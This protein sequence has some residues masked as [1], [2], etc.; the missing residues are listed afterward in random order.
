M[1]LGALLKFAQ[2]QGASDLHLE[3]GLPMCLRVRGE[4]RSTGEP[5][6]AAAIS[7]M[8]LELLSPEDWPEFQERR[9]FDLS[10]V[11]QGV[12]VRVNALRT[13]RGVGLAIRLLAPFQA[14]KTVLVIN[15][16]DRKD[17]RAPDVLDAVYSLYIDLGADETQLEFP[18][19]YAVARAGQ[20]SLKLDV[21]GTS[22]QPLFEA[23]INHISPPAAPPE[24]EDKL[25]LLV[26]NLDYDD[27]VGRLIIGR[28]HSGKITP[29]MP[30]SVV[31][32]GGKIE[33]GKIIKLFGFMGLKRTELLDAGPGEIVSIAGI[34]NVSIGDTIT[35]PDRPKA[36][37][38]ISVDE[39]TMMMVFKVN[40]GPL[41]GREGK[42][43]TS[44]NLR[45]RLYK[46]SYRNVS[47]RVEDT[48][49][50]DSFRV[51]GRGELAPGDDHRDHAPRGLRAHRLEPR[52]DHQGRRRPG[53]RADGADGLRRAGSRGGR[54]H[55]APG[56][57]QGPHGRHGHDRLGPHA[58]ATSAS[59]RAAWSASATSSS[60]SP[61]ARASCRP[62][63][64][65][66]SP[67]SATFPAR[68]NGAIVSRPRRARP[69]RTALFYDPGARRAVRHGEG[70]QV[71]EG[72]I[73]GE[74]AHPSDLE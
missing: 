6:P 35:S 10:R 45:E 68:Q 2:D 73:V 59:R 17:A 64:T 30:I 37:P 13:L 28:V 71:Y 48:D 41:A 8:A 62:S 54:G 46:E 57:P 15:K 69:W 1:E 29:N 7:A 39:P 9:S 22:L 65:A 20:A 34:E 14:L 58:P 23:I 50:A 26:D 43:V 21:P 27:Y 11:V 67:G 74:H 66:T 44:R 33:Q 52:A 31:R 51:V 5:I 56:A 36:L 47:V 32:E 42:Y 3:G 63:S 25:Q 61:A 16:I 53:A 24:G 40:D 12:R 19:I 18:V 55:R 4:L 70:A 49:S 38:R 60:P 72:M